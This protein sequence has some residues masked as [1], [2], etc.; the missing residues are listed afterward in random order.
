M[1]YCFFPLM[2]SSETHSYLVM[3]YKGP[4]TVSPWLSCRVSTQYYTKSVLLNGISISF[5]LDEKQINIL[6]STKCY[7]RSTFYL[8]YSILPALLHSS[9]LPFL[10]PLFLPTCFHPFF[11]SFLL[12]FLPWSLQSSCHLLIFLPSLLPIF[13]VECISYIQ[14]DVSSVA[15]LKDFL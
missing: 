9:I 6:Q 13:P 2:I 5:D 14:P 3:G 12:P 15:Q 1:P 10:F 7:Q 11:P 4:V 8:L